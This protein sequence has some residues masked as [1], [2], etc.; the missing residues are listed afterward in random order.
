MWAAFPNNWMKKC[1][2]EKTWV[3]LHFWFL[4]AERN[5]F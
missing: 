2:E 4:Q 5:S 1:K 3:H